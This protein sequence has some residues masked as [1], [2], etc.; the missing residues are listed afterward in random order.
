MFLEGNFFGLVFICLFSNLETWSYCIAQAGLEFVILLPQSLGCWVMGMHLCPC[1]VTAV[2]QGTRSG[3]GLAFAWLALHFQSWSPWTGVNWITL[4]CIYFRKT[5][6]EFAMA[7]PVSISVLNTQT[8]YQVP[9][10]GLLLTLR[11]SLQ[12]HRVG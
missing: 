3:T 12:P 7:A 10:G 9:A 2:P 8:V 11:A 6:T 4:L 5:L 1:L